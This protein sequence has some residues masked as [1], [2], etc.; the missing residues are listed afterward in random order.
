MDLFIRTIA[1]HMRSMKM[2]GIS[3]NR[4]ESLESIASLFNTH[5]AASNEVRHSARTE[6]TEQGGYDLQ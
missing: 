2:H 5:Q 3:W 6:E 1:M 4:L